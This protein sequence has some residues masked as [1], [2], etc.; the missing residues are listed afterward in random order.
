MRTS[1][2]VLALLLASVAW[3]PAVQAQQRDRA[4]DDCAQEQD[5]ER[6]I[7]GC[8]E[9][10]SRNN[11]EPAPNRAPAFYN[12]GNAHYQLGNLDAA[13]RDY[14]EAIRFDPRFAPAFNNRGEVHRARGNLDAAIRDFDEA[15]RIDPRIALAFNNRGQVHERRGNIGLAAADFREAM[16]LGLAQARTDL[17]RVEPAAAAP[18]A[19]A[20][21]LLLRAIQPAWIYVRDTRSGQVLVNLTLRTGETWEVPVGREGLVLDTGRA[22]GLTIELDGRAVPALAGRS[23][24]VRGIVLDPSRL[25]N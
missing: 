13:I 24:I 4:W 1:S 7:R 11:R 6:Q 16:R 3:T 18:A 22:E 8:S 25:A 20:P 15:I 21:R 23:G 19:A 17:A 12:R 5:R 2:L 14:N 10:L 9:V